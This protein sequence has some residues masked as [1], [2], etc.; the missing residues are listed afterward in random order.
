MKIVKLCNYRHW[1]W[2]LSSRE[3]TDTMYENCQAE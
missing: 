1:A 2:N 3:I